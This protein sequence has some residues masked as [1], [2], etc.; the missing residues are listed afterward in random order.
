M[1]KNIFLLIIILFSCK[2]FGSNPLD[3]DNDNFE[4]QSSDTGG[5]DDGEDS[6]ISYTYADDIQSIFSSNC[7]QCHKEGSNDV[8]YQS[9]DDMMSSGTV[10]PGNALS[11]SLYDRITR[12]GEGKMPPEWFDK[13]LT[14]EEIELIKIWIN[15]GAPMQW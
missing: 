6:S 9:Y 2:D 15:Q 14:I 10:V 4:N 13:D 5:G 3:P 11:S 1:K 12:E 7:I 8:S